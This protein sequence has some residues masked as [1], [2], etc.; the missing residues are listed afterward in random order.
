MVD[1]YGRQINYMR[2][3]I[4]D[5]CNLRCRYC[6]PESGVEAMPHTTLLT[7]EELLRI[8]SMA[9]QLG[10][11]RFKIT[12][13]EPFVRKG[14]V[15]FMAALKRLPGVEQV[16][17]TT[18]GVLLPG[19]IDALAAIGIDGVNISL[20]TLDAQQYRKI[21]R[22][23]INVQEI[24]DTI[25][26]CAEILP[27]KVNCVL[28][29]E[30]SD[31]IIPLGELAGR[32]PMDVRFIETMPIGAGATICAGRGSVLQTLQARWP[33][34]RPAPEKRGNGPAVYY[35]SDGLQGRIGMIEALHNAFCG[36]CNRVRLTSAGLLM[37]CLY[38]DTGTNLTALV[39]GDTSDAVLQQAMKETI[40]QKPKGHQFLVGTASGQRTMNQ[41]GG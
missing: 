24:V 2:I 37:P 25:A 12:G 32:F 34:L 20:D 10:I 39:R 26:R 18:N 22:S 13:G 4:T 17:V 3:S 5:R 6:M 30:T 21:T 35:Q 8:A 23:E 29:E 28:L 31:Q 41:I 14:C 1:G 27:T 33:D 15:D 7:Y 9:V 11:T 19:Y 16:T 40:Y 38:Y 36:T